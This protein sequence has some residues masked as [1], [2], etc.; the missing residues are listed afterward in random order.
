MLGVEG[1]DRARAMEGVVDAEVYPRPGDELP[2]LTD[3]AKRVG[4]ILAVGATRDEAVARADRAERS[5][6]LRVEQAGGRAS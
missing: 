6:D 5:I 4:H 1:L 3:A 2:A